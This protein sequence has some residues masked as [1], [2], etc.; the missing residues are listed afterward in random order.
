M[1]YQELVL[2]LLLL[3]YSGAVLEMPRV[4]PPP[5]PL[6]SDARIPCTFNVKDCPEEQRNFF[7]L[8]Y[9]ERNSVKENILSSHD[10]Q[11]DKYLLNNIDDVSNGNAGMTVFNISISDAGVYTCSVSWNVNDEKSSMDITVN[12][13]AT[14]KLSIVNKVV[15]KHEESVLR[16]SI[17]GYY[18]V[19]IDVK[20]FQ[21]G[22][23]LDNVIVE[24]PQRLPDGTYSVTSSVTVTPTEE[25]RGRTFSCRVQH[26]SLT[27]PLQ[28]DF[29][30][31]YGARP[32]VSIP[33]RT[34]HKN[35]ENT[36]ICKVTG[37]FPPEIEITWL[38]DGEALCNQQIGTIKR[39]DDG[40]YEKNT[41]VTIIP[42]DKDQERTYSCR[43]QHIS[44]ESPIKEDF[45]LDFEEKL[46]TRTCVASII[47]VIIAILAFVLCVLF[48]WKKMGKVGLPKVRNIT[49]SGG[50]FFS[51]DVD[52]FYPE[53]ITVSW[54]VIQ[55][56]SS[57]QP[58]PIGST[59][60]RHQNQDGTFNATST[61]ESLRGVIIEDEPYIV[62]AAVK[63]N[64]LKRP[65]Q[66][67]WN[68]DDKE[69]KA[70]QNNGR[71]NETEGDTGNVPEHQSPEQERI[72]KEKPLEESQEEEPTSTL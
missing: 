36:L 62:T 55:P 29:T 66:R 9:Y 18:P 34:V 7:V 46:H 25:D 70:S 31:V 67:E 33:T 4:S 21:D 15:I 10:S 24:K 23:I 72:N 47:I 26:E 53:D 14:P 5:Y 57:S 51:L 49:R 71:M 8:W 20:W 11:S 35:N 28:E 50:G 39:N 12:V 16:S 48:Y 59:I 41:T 65:V 37:F 38:R 44:L 30:L 58:R 42:T 3:C 27:Q 68:S 54:A 13:Q 52:N 60:V 56:P 69:N 19:D 32:H 43:V 6:G 17:S 64:K 63:H 45:K 2:L 22:E 1:G 61:S 40:T